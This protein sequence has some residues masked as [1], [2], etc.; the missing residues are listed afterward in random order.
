[1]KLH[2][3]KK[4]AAR[5]LGVGKER[6]AFNPER[7]E[8]IKEAITRQDFYDLLQSKAL[9]VHEPLGRRKKEKLRKRGPGKMRKKVRQ[10]KRTY[11]LLTRKLRAYVGE[12]LNQERISKEE[13][14]SIRKQIRARVFKSKSHLQNLLKK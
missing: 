12:L 8:E 5:S 4:L 13:H 14:R 2:K 3:K 7:L 9:F 6:I 10:R 1:M 11:L